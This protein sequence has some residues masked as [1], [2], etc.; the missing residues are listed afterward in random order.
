[1]LDI[2]HRQ[3]ELNILWDI[4]GTLLDTSGIGVSFLTQAYEAVT[5]RKFSSTHQRNQGLTDYEIVLQDLYSLGYPLERMLDLAEQILDLYVQLYEKAS[6]LNKIKRLRSL[7]ERF[8]DSQYSDSITHN[9]L[10]GNCE[11]GGLLKLRTVGISNYFEKGE[12]FFSNKK[13]WKRVQ[14]LEEA[15]RSINSKQ[16]LVI[17]DTIRDYEAAKSVGVK[18]VILNW[19]NRS[20]LARISRSSNLWVCTSSD[21]FSRE[22]ADKV[23]EFATT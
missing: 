10:S 3:I 13:N 2:D 16:V 6:N 23:F 9:I 4:D 15:C 5:K 18:A 17:G 11:R 12:F 21:I 7:D 22:F 19:N 8:L 20:E 1:M 14:I